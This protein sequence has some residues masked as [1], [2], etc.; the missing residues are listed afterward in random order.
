[1]KLDPAAKICIVDDTSSM[2]IGLRRALLKLGYGTVIEATNGQ[3][4]FAGLEAN[5]DTALV[6]S[7][8]NMAP[9]DG[10]AL[11][12]AVRADK[13]FHKLPFILISADAGPHLREKAAQ[14]DV[15]L[16][17]AK[18]FDAEKLRAAINDVPEPT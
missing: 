18:P 5:A 4:A 3:E 13:R 10:L 15:S 12:A 9:M 6:I 7:D 8:W 14:L 2:L 1:M 16:V 11:L 17:L